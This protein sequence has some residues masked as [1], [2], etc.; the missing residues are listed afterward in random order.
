MPLFKFRTKKYLGHG[1]AY[2]PECIYFWGVMFAE[3]YGTQPF[4]ERADKL[5]AS[6]WHK[7]EWV[8]GP[9]LVVLL[10]DRYAYTGDEKFLRETL[11]PA[12]RE[13]F[14]FF[15][16]HYKTGGDGK[17]D[18]QPSQAPETWV[19]CV[20]PMP[21]LAGLH[22]TTERLLALPENLTSTTATFRVIAMFPALACDVSGGIH[23][24]G[25]CAVYGTE[26]RSARSRADLLGWESS[27]Q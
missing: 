11:L 27:P 14:G 5:Q 23:R 17:L 19:G 25:N 9:E 18:M 22:A 20:N 15:D 1:G 24:P 21:E 26:S 16:Q 8:S 10:L 12:A 13:L 7:Y 6:E 3:V 2:I 4:A